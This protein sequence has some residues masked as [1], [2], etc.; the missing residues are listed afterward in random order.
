M[1]SRIRNNPLAIGVLTSLAIL[2][3]IRQASDM[4]VVV[5]ILVGAV[6]SASL[7]MRD[8]YESNRRAEAEPATEPQ[9][10]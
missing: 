4:V 3:V 6:V 1:L 10:H 8:R 7:L 5:L 2:P 9:H